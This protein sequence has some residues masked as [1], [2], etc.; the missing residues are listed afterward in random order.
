MNV[1]EKMTRKGWKNLY[2]AY[3]VFIQAHDAMLRVSLDE[4][5]Q[6]NYGQKFE[7]AHNTWLG[8]LDLAGIDR[9]DDNLLCHRLCSYAYKHPLAQY[10]SKELLEARLYNYKG[11][12]REPVG[13]FDFDA[14][15]LGPSPVAS[16]DWSEYR[17]SPE[18]GLSISQIIDLYA[19]GEWRYGLFGACSRGE[20]RPRRL[21]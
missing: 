14:E 16:W 5:Y 11:S 6:G 12:K 17:S 4:Y 8:A 21:P 13:I 15:D 19:R 18:Y 9:K 7:K 2:R 1:M 3:R 20:P 10:S